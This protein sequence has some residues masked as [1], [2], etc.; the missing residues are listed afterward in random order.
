MVTQLIS[1]TLTP[2]K[3]LCILDNCSMTHESNKMC[4]D[5]SRQKKSKV[6]VL[7]PSINIL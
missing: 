1:P 6:I 2:L 7:L 3:G 4:I 5:L